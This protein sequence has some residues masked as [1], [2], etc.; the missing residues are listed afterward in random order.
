MNR[1]FSKT[2][3][4][5]GPIVAVAGFILA[6]AK[7]LRELR[8]IEQSRFFYTTDGNRIS[9]IV[10]VLRNTGEL[11]LKI[12]SAKVRFA[13]YVGTNPAEKVCVDAL[14]KIPEKSQEQY[15]KMAQRNEPTSASVGI[16]LPTQCTA[17]SLPTEMLVGLEAS[18]HDRFFVPFSRNVGV[19][20]KVTK[21]TPENQ[22]R[23]P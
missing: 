3:K 7:T 17:E 9:P 10:V 5:V 16:I 6:Y 23:R 8:P 1:L 13:S 11:P 2:I 18:G 22:A 15:V 21:D 12:T 19:M 20:L 14:E 4:I